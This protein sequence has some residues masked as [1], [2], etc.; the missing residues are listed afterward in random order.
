MRT[1]TSDP[2]KVIPLVRTNGTLRNVRLALLVF[3]TRYGDDP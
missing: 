2:P 3:T 1:N